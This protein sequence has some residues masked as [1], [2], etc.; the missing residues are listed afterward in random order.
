MSVNKST[1]QWYCFACGE[2]GGFKTFAKKLGII[3]E[4][5]VKH[6]VPKDEIEKMHER[7]LGHEKGLK[8]LKDKRGVTQ[9][10]VSSYKLGFD[11]IR[12]WIPVKDDDGAYVNV[13]KYKPGAQQGKV[14]G[15]AAGYNKCRI[16]PA[17]AQ[18]K[19]VVY[20]M[21]GEMDVLCARSLGLPA[22]TQTAGALTWDASY[23]YY[24]TDKI[25]YI[26]Y[27]NDDQG[28]EG[29][30]VVANSLAPV[31]KRVHIVD[32][33]VEAEKEDF[34]DYI[35]KYGH[36]AEDFVKLCK[37]TPPAVTKNVLSDDVHA[38]DL[39]R[40]SD[41][42][43]F[44]KLVKLRVMVVGKDRDPY[45]LPARVNLTCSPKKSAKC[46]GC[47]L[48]AS[49]GSHELVLSRT[50]PDILNFLD[51]PMSTIKRLAADKANLSCQGFDCSVSET[52]NV[53]ALTVINDVEYI[54]DKADYTQTTVFYSGHGVRT[55]ANYEL[56]GR[57]YPEPK[58]QHATMLVHEAN[59][60]KSNIE[61]F[62]IENGVLE[63]LQLF[64]I[65]GEDDRSNQQD[66]RDSERPVS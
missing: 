45:L 37:A 10:T 51:A 13:R 46:S 41:S 9:D 50:D 16:F 27:D 31:A 49:G 25:V 44:K 63:D 21:E 1:G 22:Y 64:E 57:I 43:Y 28:R 23:N 54:T 34:T 19:T 35:V 2:G 56:V 58:T 11:G 15:Y 61:A 3:D 33:P 5:E 14:I 24:F 65:G 38:V 6:K 36:S 60:S 20:I 55:N 59:P 17:R 4:H 32:L 52:M 26:C 47:A 39:F 53:E 12:V 29:A 18:L 7:L 30:K 42:K 62:K 48:A 40:A 8:Y 66:R